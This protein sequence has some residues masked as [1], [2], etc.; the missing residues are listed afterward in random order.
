MIGRMLS[1]LTVALLAGGAA[2]AQNTDALAPEAPA[3]TDAATLDTMALDVNA[4]TTKDEARAFGEAEFKIADANADGKIELAEF[5]T[6][7]QTQFADDAEPASVAAALEGEGDISTPESTAMAEGETTVMADAGAA[8][9]ADMTAD[10]EV[11]V[12]TP[13]EAFAEISD[14][15]E[16]INEKTLV[17]ARLAA[18]D[19]A[20]TDDDEILNDAEKLEFAALVT[21]RAAS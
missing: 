14:G 4:V 10:A 21:G 13:E 20:D 19:K 11:D 12:A 8:P 16:T 7:T 1:A 2:I 5:I 3:V 17:K 18:F 9:V 6:Y 15:K